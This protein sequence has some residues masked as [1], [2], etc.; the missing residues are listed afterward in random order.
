M[1][2]TDEIFGYFFNFTDSDSPIE[3]FEDLGYEGANF[4]DL[5]GS[6]I[7]N[8][9]LV[10]AY[11]IIQWVLFFFAKKLYMFEIVREQRLK[12]QRSSAMATILGIFL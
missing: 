9:V 4:V 8:I 1:Y 11:G 5:T 2:P 12:I 10:I 6:L 3:Y 7:I